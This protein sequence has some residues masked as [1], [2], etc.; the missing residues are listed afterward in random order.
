[1]PP[2]LSTAGV[3][4]GAQYIRDWGAPLLRRLRRGKRRGRAAR[5]RS[6]NSGRDVEPMA[7]EA[8]ARKWRPKT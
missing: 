1:M 5:E 3:P 6:L 8:L 7:Y 2:V 4:Q